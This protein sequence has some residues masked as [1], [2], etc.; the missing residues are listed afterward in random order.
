MSTFDFLSKTISIQDLQSNAPAIVDE[1][2]RTN[3]EKII[4]HNNALKA[5]VI[6]AQMY[7]DYLKK[8][9][10]TP[11]SNASNTITTEGN[12]SFNYSANN[13]DSPIAFDRNDIPPFEYEYYKSTNDIARDAFDYIEKYQLLSNDTLYNLTNGLYCHDLLGLSYPLLK[14]VHN[15]ILLSTEIVI[16][17]QIRYWKQVY[18]L[19]NKFFVLYSLLYD[20]QKHALVDWLENNIPTRQIN[21]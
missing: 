15:K 21:N 9:S 4:I 8:M 20:K 18:T 5:V 13:S 16:D 7:E 2:A 12:N 3:K 1:I 11:A 17:N 10:V 14:R 6:S 19:N